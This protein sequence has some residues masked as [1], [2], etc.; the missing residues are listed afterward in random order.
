MQFRCGTL[1]EVLRFQENF[2]FNFHKNEAILRDKENN[3]MTVQAANRN[4]PHHYVP[5]GRSKLPG[6]GFES[7]KNPI[8]Q[9]FG[10]NNQKVLST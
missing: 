4:N 8:E 5:S 1:K 2:S 6:G 7:N 3:N 9:N 10:P